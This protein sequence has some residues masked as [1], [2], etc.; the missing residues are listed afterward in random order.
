LRL[1]AT[2][3]AGDPP[4]LLHRDEDPVAALEREL[5]VLPVL[6]GARP[7]EHLLVPGDTMIDVDDEVA[8]R[9]ALDDV[10]WD[11]AAERLGAPDADVAEQLAVGHE[12]E[13]VGP[14]G[15]AAVQAPLDEDYRA[16]GRRLGHP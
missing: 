1:V 9:Q 10:A 7:A 3:V 4:D 8:G 6:P 14:A 13:A 5:E 2:R 11:E 15:E 16:G 12:D